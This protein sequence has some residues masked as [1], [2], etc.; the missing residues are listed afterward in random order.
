MQ[1]KGL[2][3]RD[4]AGLVDTEIS[5]QTSRKMYETGKKPNEVENDIFTKKFT[6]GD[7]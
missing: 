7:L 3:A 5:F 2:T 1:T 6:K 4:Y